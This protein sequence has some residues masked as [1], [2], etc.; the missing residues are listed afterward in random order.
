MF[1]NNNKDTIS[2]LQYS[3][4]NTRR[5]TIKIIIINNMVCIYQRRSNKKRTYGYCSNEDLQKAINAVKSK[6]MTQEVN[7][8]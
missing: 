7:L 5:M 4:I 3:A 8:T 6:Q 1:D 2:K